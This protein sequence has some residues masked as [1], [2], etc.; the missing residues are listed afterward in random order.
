MSNQV[1]IERHK[2]LLGI[3]YLVL[4]GLHLLLVFVGVFFIAELL[5][6]AEPESVWVFNMV[7]YVVVT[8]TMVLTL[9][10]IIAGIGLLYKKDWAL[11]VAFIISIIAL[12]LFPLWT[13]LSIYTIVIFILSQ[14]KH[15]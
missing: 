10:G 6:I 4:S 9:P 11:L 13:F 14:Q 5:S 8:M 12:P 7:K 15:S 1:D 3:L 2:N